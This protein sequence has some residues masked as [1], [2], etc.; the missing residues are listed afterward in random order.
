MNLS[1]AS[2]Q[3]FISNITKAAI[4]FLG[5]AFFSQKLGASQIGIFFLFQALLGILSIGAD[6]GLRGAIEKRISEGNTKGS[7]LSTGILI[8]IIPITV[9]IV[10]IIFLQPWINE[11]LGRKLA[12]FLVISLVLKEASSLTA[13]ILRGEL[14]VG[15]TAVLTV[16]RDI[17]WVGGGV[18]LVNQG[19][20]MIALVY[21]FILGQFAMMIWGWYKISVPVDYPTLDSAR[22]LVNFGK[23]DLV[24]TVGGYFYSWMD[25][26]LIGLF[27]TQTEVGAY[28]VAW[29]VSA[30]SLLFSRA[31]AS[32]I[33][34]QVSQW[35][36]KDSTQQIESIIQK[37]ITP[38]IIFVLPSFFGIIIISSEILEIIFGSE[39]AIASTVLIILMGEKVLQ[40]IHIILSRTLQGIDK[41]GLAA[42][43]SVISIVINLALN[44]I[45]ILSLGLVG[46]AIATALSF[47]VNTILHGRYLSRFVSIKLPYSEVGW[48]VISS[49][50]MMIILYLYS[51]YVNIQSVIQLFGGILLGAAVYLL[52]VLMFRPIRQRAFSTISQLSIK[53][54]Y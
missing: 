1:K 27:L 36:A 7:V 43:A 53:G 16:A 33:L 3:I 39:F 51:S 15:E 50:L 4:S 24:S 48:C 49:A 45:L 35:N 12:I 21:T 17:V 31:V 28:E 20:D 52:I 2:L 25:V 19:Y 23:Y 22:S 10:G 6:F 30:V 13:F 37:M 11:Y 47:A 38:S 54:F 32:I 42:R 44:I 26:A 8:K 46:A 41:P 34:P 9:I 18:I 40:S 29:R 5:I 14:R